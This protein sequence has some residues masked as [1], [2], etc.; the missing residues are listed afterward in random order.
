MVVV[1]VV[2][3]A[4]CTA[5]LYR[6]C[7][8]FRHWWRWKELFSS[9][10]ATST[11]LWLLDYGSPSRRSKHLGPYDGPM[12]ALWLGFF[13]FSSH[14]FFWRKKTVLG[15]LD[16]LLDSIEAFIGEHRDER[17]M[18][19]VMWCLFFGLKES[20]GSRKGVKACKAGAARGW[21][22]GCSLG[23]QSGT[24]AAI[25]GGCGDS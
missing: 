7:G 20:L 17:P 8:P 18:F 6:L 1:V 15:G 9:V 3:A 10:P 21:V 14:F 2:V 24:V 5:F 4:A 19:L 25:A 13:T 11:L 12:M 22:H 23:T 16:G